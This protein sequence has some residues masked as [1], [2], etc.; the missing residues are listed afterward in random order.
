M[1]DN[2]PKYL[3]PGDPG[4]EFHL[5]YLKDIIERMASNSFKMK[6]WAVASAG[7]ICTVLGT[8]GFEKLRDLY[9][10]A[11]IPYLTFCLLDAY[12]LMLE[13]CFRDAYDS[14]VKDLHRKELKVDKLFVIGGPWLSKKSKRRNF[15]LAIKSPSVFLM[16]LIGII[17]LFVRAIGG[18]CA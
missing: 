16:L 18:N 12:Y 17:A 5:S 2:S 9:L 10:I 15:W 11:L 1:N 7:A 6:G 3:S 13:K 8:A 4:V 14:F